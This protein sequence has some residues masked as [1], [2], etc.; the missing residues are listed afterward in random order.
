MRLRVLGASGL[1]PL[2]NK[3]SSSY[4]LSFSDKHILIDMGSGSLAELLRLVPPEELS[5]IFISHWHFDHFSDILP[6]IYYLQ[7]KKQRLKLFAPQPRAEIYSLIKDSFDFSELVEDFTVLKVYK[8]RTLHPEPCFA[9]RFEHEGKSLV[10]TGDSAYFDELKAFAFGAD[11]LLADAAFVEKD[12][13]KKIPHMNSRQAG[14]LAQGAG[15]KRLV[16][17]HFAPGQSAKGLETEARAYFQNVSA[18]KVG[19]CYEI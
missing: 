4:L 10:F 19:A 11:L 14:E 18:A 15:V 8:Q 7:G 3:P 2:P 6:L 5:A 9:Y 17:T 13:N 12:W 1:Y 16:I